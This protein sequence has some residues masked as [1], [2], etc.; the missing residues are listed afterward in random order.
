MDDC[1]DGMDISPSPENLTQVGEGFHE[2]HHGAQREQEEGEG[3][4]RSSTQRLAP[5]VDF[6][7]S[8]LSLVMRDERTP[9]E[10]PPL[11]DVPDSS[12]SHP[13]YNLEYEPGFAVPPQMPPESQSIPARG[14]YSLPDPSLR[15]QPRV[16]LPGSSGNW[17][18]PQM[19]NRSS[20]QDFRCM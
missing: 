5:A 18:S 6:S 9:R 15:S 12:Q 20:Y 4:A 7:S 10:D 3:S 17:N 14:P 11:A 16:A 2:V 19:P 8:F 13:E 1:S